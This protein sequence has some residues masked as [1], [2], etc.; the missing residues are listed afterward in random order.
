M[1]MTSKL[2]VVSHVTITNLKL[3]MHVFSLLIILLLL[4]TNMMMFIYWL[5][6]KKVQVFHNGW[7]I[8]RRSF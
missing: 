3:Q 5:Y 7:M 8:L 1:C 2:N 6:M 4:I